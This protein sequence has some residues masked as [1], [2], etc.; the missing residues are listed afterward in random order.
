MPF[1]CN[2]IE[3]KIYCSVII[4]FRA[5]SGVRPDPMSVSPDGGCPD[6]GHGLGKGGTIFF[7]IL[8][9]V[10]SR[11]GLL[12]FFYSTIFFFFV[13]LHYFGW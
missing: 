12:T 3:I 1:E 7:L 4:T 6:S 5:L 13:S 2:R 9:M 10:I 8:V 11:C